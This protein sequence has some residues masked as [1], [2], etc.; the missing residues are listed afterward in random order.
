MYVVLFVMAFVI[1]FQVADGAEP[2][3]ATVLTFFC[4]IMILYIFMHLALIA[5]ASCQTVCF[6]KIYEEL[7]PE[8]TLKYFLL[9]L[10]VPLAGGICL[11]KFSK[12]PIG[13][14]LDPVY[15]PPVEMPQAAE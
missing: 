8:K 14:P 13:V 7:V 5:L 11:L 9:T 12:S 3:V 10:L 4:W 15:Q 2:D 1:G 6:Y